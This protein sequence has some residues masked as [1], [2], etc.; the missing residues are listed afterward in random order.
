MSPLN[1]SN[2]FYLEKSVLWFILEYATFSEFIRI[3]LFRVISNF[4]QKIFFFNLSVILVEFCLLVPNIC[5]KVVNSVVKGDFRAFEVP[6]SDIG[7]L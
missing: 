7:P 4:D 2:P 5:P 1:S 3:L 6:L